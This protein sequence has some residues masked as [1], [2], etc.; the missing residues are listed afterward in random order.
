M[1]TDKFIGQYLARDEETL[2]HLI[3]RGQYLI[4]GGVCNAG[5]IEEYKMKSDDNFSIDENIDAFIEYIEEQ[6]ER[7]I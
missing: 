6:E 5:L 1:R 3:Q 2:F 7:R 4:G